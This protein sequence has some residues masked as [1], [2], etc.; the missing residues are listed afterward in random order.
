MIRL[1]LF[2]L[3]TGCAVA[4]PLAPFIEFRISNNGTVFLSDSEDGTAEGTKLLMPPSES[5]LLG[6]GKINFKALGEINVMDGLVEFRITDTVIE[7]SVADCGLI[8]FGFNFLHPLTAPTNSTVTGHLEGTFPKRTIDVRGRFFPT[9]GA[10]LSSSTLFGFFGS[11]NSSMNFS[12]VPNPNKGGF[13]GSNSSTV[14]FLDA[15]VLRGSLE[16]LSMKKGDRVE[17]PDSLVFTATGPFVA[18]VV[19]PEP[20]TA[21]LLAAGATALFALLRLR[22][23]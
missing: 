15:I 8:T 13:F 17:L 7:C 10:P 1:I 22:R 3:V 12:F 16:I 2:L 5:S 14:G 18:P 11:A 6:G 20:A 4:G 9:L 21:A 19:I 23:P